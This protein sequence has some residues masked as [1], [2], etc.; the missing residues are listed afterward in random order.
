MPQVRALCA[1]E[2]GLFTASRDKSVKLWTEGADG[3]LAVT[4]TYVGH[5]SYV[6]AVAY[7]APGATPQWPR[8]ALVS[9]APA[10][11]SADLSL[12]GRLHSCAAYCY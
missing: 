8:G 3:K 10:R 6:T 4:T 1:C 7:I 12:R 11:A 9:G 5:T 2:L